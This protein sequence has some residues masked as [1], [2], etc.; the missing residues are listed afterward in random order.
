MLSPKM[1][2]PFVIFDRDGTLIELVP[3]LKDEKEI[4]FKPDVIEAFLKLKQ[5]NFKFG[6]ITNQSGI[7]RGFF[8]KHKVEEINK[9][10]VDYLKYFH[11]E[12]SFIFYCPHH[13]NENC[14]CRKPQTYLGEQ[15]IREFNMDLDKT[16]M[17]GDQ[18]SDLQFGLALGIRVVQI[19]GKA[20]KSPL[21]NHY[22]DTL[23]DAANWII[24]Q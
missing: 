13:P 2:Q 16:F 23:M 6:M 12:I 10:I 14:K 15:A 18:E 8:D 19:K 21:A 17:I 3:Y 22:S 4:A 11:I 1:R 9:I 7:A 24:N 5:K 20:N